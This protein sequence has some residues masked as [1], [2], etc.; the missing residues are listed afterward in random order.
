MVSRDEM[1]KHCLY[2]Q[3]FPTALQ[4]GLR[5]LWEANCLCDIRLVAEN[6]TFSAHKSVL[7][8]ASTYFR[9]M[10]TAD[11]R[12]KH[13]GAVE[14]K[15]V[16]ASGLKV[17]LHFMYTSQLSADPSSLE[18]VLLTATYLQITQLTECCARLLQGALETDNFFTILTL[19]EKYDLLPLKEACLS[20]I[21]QNLDVILER[22]E[23]SLLRLDGCSLLTLLQRD[24]ISPRMNE[25]AIMS[26][27]WR[28]L[29][30][31]LENRLPYLE[32]LVNSVRLGLIFPPGYSFED[33]GENED[34]AL[35]KLFPGAESYIT[36]LSDPAVRHEEEGP[37]KNWFRIRST[38]KGVLATC[39]KT[40]G[41]QGCQEIMILTNDEDIEHNS[42]RTITQ[43]EAKYNH[44]SLVLDD[45][46]YIIGGQNS[47]LSG[48]HE[49]E[50]TAS[51]HRYDPRFN[52]WARLTD[53]NVC[54]RRF[55]CS[56]MHGHI[57]A[58]GGRGEGGILFS[59]ERYSLTENKWKYIKT[60]PCPLS[61]HAG[62]VHQNKLYVSGGSSGEIFSNSVYRY[63]EQEN[64][65]EVLSPLR[66][67]RGFH[68][69]TSAGDK[70]Y[71]IGGVLI[72]R[73]NRQSR[74]YSDVKVTECYCPSTNQWTELSPLPVGHSQHGTT[75]LDNMVYIIGGFS[76]WYEGFLSSVHVYN[77]ENDTWEAGPD[78]P[79]PLVGLSSGTLI[80]PHYLNDNITAPS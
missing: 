74:S 45:Y 18:D 75:V 36:V 11:M 34:V 50:A 19:S 10:F 30:H 49:E 39:G 21:S 71:V 13:M 16:T 58:V 69:M 48:N 8:A 1:G 17:A 14:L 23:L 59:A 40:N 72:T 38:R 79:R 33:S 67:A 56:A 27:A 70:I 57:Y 60:L 6:E 42:W 66:Y 77:C 24:D 76:W 41:S 4:L 55:H 12:E 15:G 62:T 35:L 43:A 47:L 44:C 54:R 28:W 52:Q 9:I 61:S 29:R 7:A 51:V 80:L 2:S 31:D 26:L 3:D 25:R 20:F 5:E 37:F 73:T 53:M 68:S 32:C 46:L 78:L 65:W 22:H 63:S 64:K